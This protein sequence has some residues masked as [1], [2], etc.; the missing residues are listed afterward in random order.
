MESEKGD[1]LM[2]KSKFEFF[3]RGRFTYLDNAATT[4]VPDVVIRAAKNSLEFRG[5]PHRGAHEIAERNEEKI[6]SARRNIGRFVNCSPDEIVFTGNTT[7]SINLAVKSFEHLLKKDDEVI[8]S[9]AEH[10]S[11]I[12]PYNSLKKKGVKFHFVELRDGIVNSEQLKSFL[13][14]KTKVVALQHC[15][16][17]LGNINPVEKIGNLIKK[18]NSNII[19]VI[20]GAQSIAHI[21]VDFKKIKCDYFAFS[22]HKMYGPD[23]IGVL[24]ISKKIWTDINMIKMGGGTVADVNLIKG[25]KF[26]TIAYEKINSLVGMEGGTPNVSNIIGLSEAVDF[27]RLIGFDKIIE[28]EKRLSDYLIKELGSIEGIKIYGPKNNKKRIGVVSFSIEDIDVKELGDFLGKRKI[29]IRNGSHCAFL[30]INDLKQENLRI[31]F[32]IY[33]DLDDLQ[34]VIQEINFFID[35]KKGL[36][37]NPNLEKVKNMLY[38]KNI[39]PVNSQSQIMTKILDSIDDP[40]NTDIVIM[41]GHFLAVPDIKDN[42]FYPSIKPLM[43]ERLYGL[44]DEFGMTSFP[45][46]TWDFA[47]KIKNILSRNNINNVKLATIANDT[48]GINELKS[49]AANKEDKSAEKYRN[50]LLKEYQQ[51]KI[52]E[53]YLNILDKYGLSFD[54]VL[55]FKGEHF[56]RES[57]LRS[58]FQKFIRENKKYFEDMIDYKPAKD[59]SWDL[60]IKVLDNEQIKTCRFDTFQSKT[61]GKFCIVEL[62]QFI[63]ELF[64]TAKDIKFN[65]L[66]ENV[67]TPHMKR[68]D[69][70]LI[71]LTPAMCGDAVTRGAE[72]YSKLMLQ[73]K[74]RGSFK[75]FNIPLG[76]DSEKYLATGS[77]INYI[78]D[79]GN[80]KE[81]IVDEEPNVSELWKLIEYELLY[82]SKAYVEEMEAVFKKI[83]LS[84][85]SKY[86]DTCVGPGFFCTELL[87]KGYNLKTS[88]KSQEMIK[89]FLKTLK[90]EGIEHKVV[91]SSWLNLHKHF[92]KNS[93]DMLFN[94]GNT[95]I[96]ANGGWNEKKK[97]EKRESLNAIK[98]TLKIY[99]NLLKKGGYLYVDKYKDS[100]IPGKKIAAKLKI[101]KTKE[102]KDIIFYVERKPEKNLRYA[103]GILKDKSGHEKGL[104]NMA[105][106]LTE[107]EMETLLKEVGFTVIEKMKMKNEKH[108]VVWL[109]KK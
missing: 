94:R 27:I 39:L 5:N 86:L 97:I 96:Y 53:V 92:K 59:G 57:I 100:E 61:G 37:S 47:C 58:R 87:E 25:K 93:F 41:G 108:F 45:L 3:R 103:Q 74:N 75:F 63:A 36:I 73:E 102:D 48:T 68:R 55:Q 54:S 106:D 14:S 30:L 101:K 104:P 71:M 80:L 29:A 22:G 51:P 26:D 62:C 81:I 19:Y 56:V 21:P 4:Q 85:K 32:G 72:L 83:G 66:S 64:G 24:V 76:P 90:K 7:D 67:R 33:N 49:S 89:P 35:K 2:L 13:N 8:I 23:G 109:A 10:N 69:K 20:D 52:P 44:L 42:Q 6:N 77:E 88:D 43:P 40:E 98:K 70:I 105:Y 28:H 46:Y 82:D 95:L 79:K 15:S 17:V 12:L 65:Y 50:E 18:F 91:I 11:N 60:D 38:Y 99:Y 9:I 16:N 78:S 31:S 84:K 1:E 107:N 34:R